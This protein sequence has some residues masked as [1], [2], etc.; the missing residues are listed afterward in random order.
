MT[1]EPGESMKAGGFRWMQY[2]AIVA[3]FFFVV[4]TVCVVVARQMRPKPFVL[5]FTV[6]DIVSMKAGLDPPAGKTFQ[7]PSSFWAPILA[8]LSPAHKDEHPAKW[9]GFGTLYVERDDG[10]PYVINLF[11]RDQ[12]AAGGT[13]HERVYYRGADDV[14]LHRV[15]TEAYEASQKNK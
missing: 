1:F 4:G 6:D 14:A 8:A 10:S 5:P 7:I 13:V 11:N 15:I 9:E 12:F 3:A 2:A